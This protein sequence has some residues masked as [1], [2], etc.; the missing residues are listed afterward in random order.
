MAAKKKFKAAAKAAP[1]AAAAGPDDSQGVVGDFS[2]EL[3]QGEVDRA[4]GDY[5]QAVEVALDTY[6]HALFHNM[7]HRIAGIRP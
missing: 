7:V 5:L 6:G 3:R 4:N 2:L 1:A